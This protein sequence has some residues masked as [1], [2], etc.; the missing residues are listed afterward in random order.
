MPRSATRP[1]ICIILNPHA[2]KGRAAKQR[3]VI[4]AA[5]AEL[6]VPIDIHSTTHR[7][8][9]IPLAKEAVAKGYRTIVAAGGDGTMN[10]VVDGVVK[11]SREL[12]LVE[13]DWPN[14]GLIP[15]GRGNDFAFFANIPKDVVEACGVVAS[16]TVDRIDYGELWGGR[17][18]QESRCFINGVGIGF[19]PLVNYV[20]SE[21]KRVGGML[22]YVLGFIKIMFDYPAPVKVA[23]TS[24]EESF[25]CDTQQISL[26]N[27]RRMG[28]TFIMGPKAEL[29]D[30]MLDVVYANRP[31]AGHEI[32]RY[33]L[34][35]F[36]GSQLETD[37][38]SM[39]RSREVTI[40]ADEDSLVCHTDGEAV[41]RGCRRIRVKLFPGG[42]KILRKM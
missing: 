9:A 16:G 6:S 13:E 27:G 17:F 39:F 7:L 32:L 21:F 18:E 8:E 26:C 3:S 42:L 34:K 10:E 24:E 1:E 25:T 30:G 33:A 23:I 29:D 31:I 40:E 28:S 15:V 5:F 20:A 14:V 38:F 4:E 41:S 35:F 12:G 37:R 22:S 11:A 19:E 36:S 2:A